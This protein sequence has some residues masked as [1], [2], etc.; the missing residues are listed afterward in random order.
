MLLE[1]ISILNST[2]CLYFFI[3]L[4][5]VIDVLESMYLPIC[6]CFVYSLT[7]APSI[8]VNSR[9]SDKHSIWQEFFIAKSN[10]IEPRNV[11]NLT[12]LEIYHT[13]FSKNLFWFICKFFCRFLFKVYFQKYSNAQVR[14]C[15]IGPKCS[16]KRGSLNG[17]DRA[18]IAMQISPEKSTKS[19]LISSQDSDLPNYSESQNL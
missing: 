15:R 19:P 5:Q 18:T 2:L 17:R 11:D 8:D 3:L 9:K 14:F 12:P 6:N 7:R 1:Y 10:S 4:G 13:I 16:S